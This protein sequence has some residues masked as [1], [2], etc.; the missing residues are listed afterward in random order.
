MWIR[1]KIT[2]LLDTPQTLSY[3]NHVVY[4][5]YPCMCAQIKYCLTWF[6]KLFLI[7]E[8]AAEVA[9]HSSF[10][11]LAPYPHT[12]LT[13]SKESKASLT[14]KK[15]QGWFLQFQEQALFKLLKKTRQIRPNYLPTIVRCSRQNIPGAHMTQQKHALKNI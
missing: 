6:V 13:L 9:S 10:F 3:V 15:Y 5:T 12:V 11:L 1:C 8:V 7:W 14:N 2:L 4:S